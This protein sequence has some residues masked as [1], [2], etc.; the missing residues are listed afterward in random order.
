MNKAVTAMICALFGLIIGSFLNV[1]L[2]RVPR[3]MSIVRP[4]SRCG[5]CDTPIRARDNVPVISWLLLRGRC[6]ACRAPISLRYPAVELLTGASY[7]AC[8]R[9][10]GATWSLPAALAGLTAVIVTVG[11]GWERHRLA[12]VDLNRTVTPPMGTP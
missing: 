1:V 9:V 5:S 11:M 8:G 10:I 6:R 12:T 2:H 4:G 3:R 7:G